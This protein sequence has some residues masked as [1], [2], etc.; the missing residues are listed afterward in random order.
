MAEFLI[1]GGYS[2]KGEVKLSGAKNSALAIL[3]ACL[4]TEKKCLIKNVPN[5]GDVFS[6]LAI[7]KKI[8]VKVK[9]SPEKNEVEIQAKNITRYRLPSD[10]V[11]QFRASVLLVGPLLAR[12]GKVQLAQ[13]GGCIIGIRSIDTHLHAFQQLGAQV[14]KVGQEYLIQLEKPKNK[15]VVLEELSV[16]TTENILMTLALAKAKTEIHLAALD[17]PILDLIN[18]LR[19]LG[20]R[21]QGARTNYLTVQGRKSLRGGQYKVMNDPIEAATLAI[22]AALT[23]GEV[24]IKNIPLEPLELFLLKLKSIGVNFEVKNQDLYLRPSQE[25]YPAYIRTDIY[26]GLLTDF[27]SPLA[28]LLTQAKGKSLIFE[29]MFEDRLN[30]VSELVRMGARA[31]ILNPHQVEIFGPTKLKGIRLVTYDLRAGAALVL[32]GL[33]AQGETIIEQIEILER[34][35][36]RLEEKLNSLGAQIIRRESSQVSKKRKAKCL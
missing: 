15:M 33:I 29:T 11:T 4:L 24:V 14:K 16:T 3:A 1:K 9:H 25:F 5:I 35:Y 7:F 23:K 30:Y 8:G 31:N 28:V 17:Y 12:L 26:P 32:A 6:M 18:F 21:I 2:L 34:G 19:K 27:Q 36:E 10:L 13:P 20:V 22:A